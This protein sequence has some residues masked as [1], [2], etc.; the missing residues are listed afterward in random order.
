MSRSE[1]A[2]RKRKAAEIDAN[3]SKEEPTSKARKD[4]KTGSEY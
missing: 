2:Q 4:E 1:T 3:K